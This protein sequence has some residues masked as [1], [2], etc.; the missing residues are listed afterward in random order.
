MHGYITDVMVLTTTICVL[1][2]NSFPTHWTQKV[3]SVG[4][5]VYSKPLQKLAAE[6]LSIDLMSSEES[7]EDGSFIVHPLP[8]RSRK[9]C[10]ILGGPHSKE[11]TVYLLMVIYIVYL[12]LPPSFNRIP[13]PLP[14]PILPPSL[15]PPSLPPPL[16]AFSRCSLASEAHSEWW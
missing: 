12:L 7:D 5:C 1:P 11:C 10:E 15:L 13:L 9:A 4:K 2:Q 8:W 6:C 16:T 3:T 14:P